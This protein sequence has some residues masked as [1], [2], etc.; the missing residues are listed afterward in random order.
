MTMIWSD[1][2]L[3]EAERV[4]LQ[5][6]RVPAEAARR[7]VG[8]VREAFPQERVDLRDLPAGEDLRRLTVDPGDQ[9]VCALAVTGRA[10]LL[11]T[12][13]R[14][15]LSIPLARHGIEVAAPDV[16]PQPVLRCRATR[17]TERAQIAGKVL[18]WWTAD[19]RAARCD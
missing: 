15:Y 4:L 3:A 11:L 9:H 16:F 14:D 7:W 19:R 1:E 12:F 10:D 8:Y 17:V 18:G 2:L 13:D 5:R 6:K